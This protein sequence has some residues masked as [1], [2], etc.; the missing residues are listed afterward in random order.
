[1]F[2]WGL[3]RAEADPAR[4]TVHAVTRSALFH[5]AEV[6]SEQGR[7]R[8]KIGD[9]A[10]ALPE[11]ATDRTTERERKAQRSGLQILGWLSETTSAATLPSS[12]PVVGPPGP[13]LVPVDLEILWKGGPGE[14]EPDISC[15]TLRAARPAKGETVSREYLPGFHAVKDKLSELPGNISS[16]RWASASLKT[17]P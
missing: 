10:A 8:C 9:I 1:M 15:R 3:S 7:T 5:G 4:H 11:R 13:Y 6:G 14:R 2:S 12:S 17:I 16:Q